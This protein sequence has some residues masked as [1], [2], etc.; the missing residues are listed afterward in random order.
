MSFSI[1]VL[2]NSSALPT[3]HRHPSAQ[4]INVYE[5]FFLVDCGEGAQMQLR[6]NKIRFSKI[7]QIFISHLHG[8]HCFGLL[9]LIS[10][11]NLLGRNSDLHIYS[12]SELE[13]ILSW[14]IKYFCAD[15]SFK[16]V[17]HSI[18]PDENMVIFENSHITVSTIPLNHRIPTCG[19]LFK[20][21]EKLRHL[22]KDMIDF[23]QIPIKKLINIKS[24]EDFVTPEG[25]IIPNE[26]LTRP[27]DRSR[28]Y[29]FCTDTGYTESI[30]P[31]IKDVD[32]LYHESTF[33][34]DLK[35][36]AEKTFHSTAEN[37]A[38]IA[39]KANVKKL[40]LGHFSSRYNDLTLF[41]KEAEEIFPNVEI[42]EE[43]KIFNIDV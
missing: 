38:Q 10:T 34:S 40:L 31:I 25:K 41:I 21:K 13:K 3:S 32:I 18:D 37:A 14:Q 20:E 4:I 24:G 35:T 2:G 17:Y 7:N 6:K 22:Q 27:A 23:Y 16:I 36:M 12:H 28:S 8:D 26:R 42:A 15:L 29:A 1:T 33:L 30:I 5:H 11:Y 39:L 19:F 9:G 43:N